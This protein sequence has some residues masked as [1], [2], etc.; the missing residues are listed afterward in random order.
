VRAEVAARAASAPPFFGPAAP[1][2]EAVPVPFPFVWQFFD[3][4][5]AWMD[6]PCARACVARHQV[7]SAGFSRERAHLYDVAEFM[8]EGFAHLKA[9]DALRLGERHADGAWGLIHNLSYVSTY[10]PFELD[11]WSWNQGLPLPPARGLRAWMAASNESLGA[12]LAAL[13]LCHNDSEARPTALLLAVESLWPAWSLFSGR[14]QGTA[15]RVLDAARHWC[16]RATLVHKTATAS[17]IA[18]GA[19]TWQRMYGASRAAEAAAAERG[20]PTLDAF[21]MTQPWAVNGSVF[22]DG[23][24]NYVNMEQHDAALT[25]TGNFVSRTIAQLWLRKTCAGDCA[26]AA[27]QAAD[28]EADDRRRR[29]RR[30]GQQ[31]G[32]L[33]S[34]GRAGA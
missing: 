4:T 6:A 34:A 29:S 7:A 2:A 31:P 28:E 20:V 30:A 19:L 24:H 5:L 10:H 12:D 23:L 25:A 14:W 26:G 33:R 18:A 3:C 32:Q 11:Q 22:P 8:D 21:V 1:A 27:G 13:G 16:P 15:A 17:R 9:H